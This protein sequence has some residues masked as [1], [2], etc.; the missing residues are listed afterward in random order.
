MKRALVILTLA[1]VTLPGCEKKDRP[2]LQKKPAVNTISTA[3][4]AGSKIPAV[5]F[6][7]QAKPLGYEDLNTLFIA[8]NLKKGEGC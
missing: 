7:W 1:A 5:W 2:D 6:S 3:S 8:N 4:G